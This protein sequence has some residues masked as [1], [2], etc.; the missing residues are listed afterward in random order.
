MCTQ[1]STFAIDVFPRGKDY[2]TETKFIKGA[3]WIMA[4]P[5]QA[6]E[7]EAPTTL[8]TCKAHADCKDDLSI[9]T[10]GAWKCTPRGYCTFEVDCNK[11]ADCEVSAKKTALNKVRDNVATLKSLNLDRVKCGAAGKCVLGKKA[12]V[13]QCGLYSKKCTD[14]ANC[15]P[16]TPFDTFHSTGRCVDK[17]FNAYDCKCQPGWTDSNCDRD[18]NECHTGTHQCHRDAECVNRVGDY[19]CECKRGYQDNVAACRDDPLLPG[20]GRGCHDIDDCT[21]VTPGRVKCLHATACTDLGIESYK[22][23]CSPGWSD[24][25]CNVDINECG[26]GT[27]ECVDS[28][29]CINTEGSYEC[30]CNLGYT[31]TGI[32]ADPGAELANPK[33]TGCRHS[34]DDCATNPCE[35][36]EC[37]DDGYKAYHC[38][39]EVG[40][41]DKNCD[42]NVNECYEKAK[43]GV[44]CSEH[45]R[46][47]DTPGSF[48]CRCVSGMA[49]DGYTCTDLDDCDPNPCG[50][51]KE[52]GCGI[53]PVRGANPFTV[54]LSKV[55]SG[56]HRGEQAQGCWDMGA[57]KYKCDCDQGWEGGDCCT[58]KDECKDNLDTC[59]KEGVPGTKDF[60]RIATCKDT[61]G[62]YFCECPAEHWDPCEC[63]TKSGASCKPEKSDKGGPLW[64][65][66]ACTC[67]NKQ[68]GAK[69][70]PGRVCNKCTQCND[71]DATIE[72]GNTYYCPV[73]KKNGLAYSRSSQALRNKLR[74]AL[75]FPF[76][77]Q[78]IQSP[79]S[80][81]ITRGPGFR[82]AANSPACKH[83]DRICENVNECV[84]PNACEMPKRKFKDS[85]YKTQ[86]VD[87]CGSYE[88]K[89]AGPVTP[90]NCW[91]QPQGE[92][93]SRKGKNSGCM[94]C[95][96]CQVGEFMVREAT[97]T[98]NRVCRRLI[99]DGLY[100]IESEAGSVKQCLVHWRQANKI[101]PE[102]YQWGG[103]S[104]TQSDVKNK[105]NKGMAAAELCKNPIC[106][107]CPWGGK[108]PKKNIIEGK[109]A[110]WMFRRLEGN[111]YIILSTGGDGLGQRCLGYATPASPYPQALW[112][113]SRH[114]S[115]QGGKCGYGVC[116]KDAKR[117]CS[118]NNDCA[119]RNSVCRL[120]SCTRSGGNDGSSLCKRYVCHKTAD[121]T[122]VAAKAG[123]SSCYA[124]GDAA[125][126]DGSKCKVG[127]K[128]LGGTNAGKFCA[129][130]A[131]CP[132][133]DTSKGY[134]DD[135]GAC[136]I[137]GDMTIGNW[138][139]D[140]KNKSPI[141]SAMSCAKNPHQVA[142]FCGKS[143][144]ASLM[145]QAPNSAQVV[146]EVLP[147][148][149]EK[150]KEGGCSKQ[151][152]P[153][154]FVIGM[155][156][157]GGKVE[158][159]YF[160]DMAARLYSNPRR[161]PKV[162]TQRMRM[163]DVVGEGKSR[164]VGWQ[165]NNN[166]CGLGVA[167]GKSVD[168]ALLANK[169]AVFKLI[170]LDE[171]AVSER[172]I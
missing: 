153:G 161:T 86:C 96:K 27:H 12:E 62:S 164:F 13:H 2:S 152:S 172:A 5:V 80:S 74:G 168:D 52:G 39:C 69:C 95:T 22:C 138:R 109:E 1:D 148:G 93:F 141:P 165:T 131:A 114:A 170:R 60:K 37:T 77:A 120:Q 94:P 23:T 113:K 6:E 116:S 87:T 7:V 36:G 99:P 17:G 55:P 3:S 75:I 102:R 26:M 83:E 16:F 35:H 129:N 163:L 24:V 9:A 33:A 149:C 134:C 11:D 103:K 146:W 151:K 143:S 65:A 136:K 158:C 34:E 115:T 78:Y 73:G 81:T 70:L 123:F 59:A 139:D 53:N 42:A 156:K 49:G 126:P 45:G 46:C 58:N 137:G 72:A 142:C 160:P 68:T 117:K 105:K 101:Y 21:L 128:C 29:T 147:L 125:C 100:A 10:Q 90:D 130:D 84:R 50:A 135:V 15:N 14:K 162:L 140:A 119:K 107:V 112:W 150:T 32:K 91:Y 57:N 155:K 67:K 118:S 89:C 111:S 82:V 145:G 66:G 38:K 56:I 41:M 4:V 47:V 133:S 85:E 64:L 157:A 127:N 44:E 20:C 169:A 79:P 122:V 76:S 51:A 92:Q 124:K 61:V 166:L 106:G 8:K 18:I 30:K 104:R 98:S 97:S 108:T 171:D 43:Y 48:Y 88:C 25:D 121:N 132:D 40:W 167:P 63:K 159:M 71:P 154:M 110:A 144:K 54:P 28:A 31:G 19:R